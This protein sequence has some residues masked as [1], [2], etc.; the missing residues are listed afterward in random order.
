MLRLIRYRYQ[1][2]VTTVGQCPRLIF[3]YFQSE[4]MFLNDE[5]PKFP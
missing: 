3:M 1:K 2:P 5:F 4:P